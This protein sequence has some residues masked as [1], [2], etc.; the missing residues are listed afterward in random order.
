MTARIS[1]EEKTILVADDDRNLVTALSIRLQAWGFNVVTAYDGEEAYRQAVDNNPDVMLLDMR[2]PAG[3][4]LTCLE[5]MKHSMS[6]RDIPV[7]F[8]TAFE[9]DEAREQ[10]SAFGVEAFFRK[11]FE[12]AELMEAIEGALDR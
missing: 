3:G 6:T 12:D 8:I 9:D 2:M 4:G 10:A 5:K 11:P 1:A 7:I